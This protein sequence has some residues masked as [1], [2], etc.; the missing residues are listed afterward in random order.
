MYTVR[1]IPANAGEGLGFIPLLVMGAATAV[2]AIV[3]K[4]RRDAANRVSPEDARNAVQQIYLEL[5]ERDPLNPYDPG[6]E[7]HADCLVK[8]QCT[9][10]TIR[11]GIL[12]GPEFRELQERKAAR[13]YGAAA[14]GAA[15]GSSPS[16]GAAAFAP[17]SFPSF[18]LGGLEQY[19]PLAIGGFVL[20]MFLRR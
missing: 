9:V 20:L 17:S 8:R 6:I 16:S 5:L 4:R 13:V 1:A 11:T 18:G 19:L 10:D 2:S 7:G 12:Q 3:A 14:T 15:A